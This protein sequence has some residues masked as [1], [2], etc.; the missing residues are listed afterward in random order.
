MFY[1]WNDSM[2]KEIFAEAEK[3]F[4]DH[5]NSET[6]LN[7]LVAFIAEHHLYHSALVMA[8]SEALSAAQHTARRIITTT[9]EDYQ[10]RTFSK[11]MQE[12]VQFSIG[13][14][15]NWPLMNGTPLKDSTKDM[16]LHD[17]ARYR[18]NARGN[19]RSARFLEMVAERLRDGQKVGGALT[20]RQLA[21]LMDKA[22]EE[23]SE[24]VHE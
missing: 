13:K 11:E 12:S 17:A 9:R 3:Q 5:G 21:T 15:L 7:N 24:L 2:T 10:P 23:V 1:L 14:F 19:M 16:I 4:L 18:K 22:R 20:D 6:A 8:A